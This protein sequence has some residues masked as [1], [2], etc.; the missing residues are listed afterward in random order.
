MSLAAPRLWPR[1]DP[2]GCQLGPV[3]FVSRA[4]RAAVC[5]SRSPEP[6][7]GSPSPA[8]HMHGSRAASADVCPRVNEATGHAARWALL[9]RGQTRPRARARGSEQPRRSWASSPAQSLRGAGSL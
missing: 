3:F 8:G 9:G 5:T 7:A 4:L 2:L 6:Q 1:A